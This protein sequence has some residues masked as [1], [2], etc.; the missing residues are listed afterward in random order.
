[1][2]SEFLKHRV[3]A[4]RELIDTLRECYALIENQESQ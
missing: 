3:A 1:M 4:D 2:L